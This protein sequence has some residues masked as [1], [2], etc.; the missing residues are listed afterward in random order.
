M[1]YY[2]KNDRELSLLYTILQPN[3]ENNATF[4]TLNEAYYELFQEPSG[5]PHKRTHD[6]IIPL[7]KGVQPINLKPYKYSS[8]QKDV[9]EKMVKE[10]MESG[11]N[12]T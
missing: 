8:L 6:H 10:M 11:I 5:V 7:K 1:N 3:G 9:V 4:K 12:P 2:I